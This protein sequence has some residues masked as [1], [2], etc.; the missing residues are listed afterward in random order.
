MTSSINKADSAHEKHSILSIG[1]TFNLNVEAKAT[2][3]VEVDLS[4][5]LAYSIDSLQLVFPPSQGGSN[6]NP[7][8][9]DSREFHRYTFM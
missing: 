8:P 1:P 2:V 3:D 5:G 4:L 7:A 6:A 9:N